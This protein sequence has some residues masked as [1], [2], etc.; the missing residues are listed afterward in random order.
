MQCVL[1]K[2]MILEGK[3]NFII[4]RNNMYFFMKV[5]IYITV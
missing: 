3:S 1:R 2:F 4:E 5:C